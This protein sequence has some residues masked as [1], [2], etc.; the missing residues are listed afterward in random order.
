MRH[1]LGPLQSLR[2]VFDVQMRAHR[3]V[4]AHRLRCKGPHDLEG[5]CHPQTR[6][7]MRC[8]AGD[9]LAIKHD[10]AC[11]GREESGHQREQCRFACAVGANQRRQA[12]CRHLQGDIADRREAAK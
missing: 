5:A 9:V 4:L 10:R 1:A 7:H 11:I 3:N 8:L 12:A 2:P 6:I